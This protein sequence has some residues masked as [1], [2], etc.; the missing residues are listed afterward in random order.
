MIRM[1]E[2][3]ETVPYEERITKL[4]TLLSELENG[5]VAL[6][7]LVEKYEEAAKLLLSCQKTLEAA[8]LRISQISLGS[9][10]FPESTALSDS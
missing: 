5:D 9:D 2:I 1:A 10:G 7:E 4:E 8:E 6:G 3:S